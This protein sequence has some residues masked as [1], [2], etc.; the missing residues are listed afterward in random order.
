MVAR[1]VRFLKYDIWNMQLEQISAGR[2]FFFKFVRIILLS[3]RGFDEDKCSLRASALTFYTMLSLVPVLA[4]AFGVAKGFG[5]EALLERQL[6]ERMQGQDEVARYILGFSS[7]MLENTRGGM[8]AGVG[9]VLLFWTVI[10][11]L[12]NIEASFNAIWGVEKG[13]TLARKCSDYLSAMLLCPLLLIMASAVNV[14]ISG[15]VRVF[16]EKL[17]LLELVGPAVFVML[18]LLP[19]CVMWGLLSFLYMFMPNTGVRAGAALAGGV[20]AGTLYQALQIVYIGFQVG[21]AQYNAIYG[22]FA[23]LPLFLIWLNL[24]WLVVL[25]GAEISFA[26]QHAD[27]YEF[28]PECRSLSPGYLRLMSLWVMHALVKRFGEGSCAPGVDDISRLLRMPARLVRQILT[29]LTRCGM[30]S[31]VSGTGTSRLGYQ[32]AR[33]ISGITIASVVEALDAC[34]GSGLP[35][36]ENDELECLDQ[37]LERFRTLVAQSPHNRV[38]AGL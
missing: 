10:K 30:A 9:I 23:A 8:V 19:Y 29:D 3:V 4:M 21:V 31:E 20:V 35:V 6:L 26:F 37:A 36:L 14:L 1:I 38:L 16:I 13:R 18:K 5:F 24:S 7:S 33:D 27:T 22:G 11:L 34:G 32:P 25:L 2:A 12:G 28:E 17:P 15:Q